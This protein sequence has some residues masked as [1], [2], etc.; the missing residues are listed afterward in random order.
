MVTITSLAKDERSAR[1]VLAATSEPDDSR[2]GRLVAAV[3][4]VDTVRVAMSDGALPTVLDPTEGELWRRQ[5]APRL[6]VPVV[7]TARKETD[8]LG[9][10]VLIPGDKDWPTGVSALRDREPLA[11]WTKGATSF[12]SMPLHDRVTFS[13]A[14]AA[15]SYGVHVTT[16]LVAELSNEEMFIVSGGAYG[17]DAAAHKAALAT[18]GSTIAVMAGGLDRP[19]PSGNSDLLS[20]VGDLGV[21]VSELPPGAAPTRW[22][23]LARNRIMAALSS[24]TIIPEAGYRS[25][26]LHVAKEAHELGRE[27]GAIPGAITSAASAGAH[28][29]IREGIAGIVTTTQDIRE[30]IEESG[31]NAARSFGA[32]SPGQRRAASSSPHR[33]L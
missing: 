30:M 31:G 23:F 16:E 28:R 15:T 9:L 6:L 14:R 20:R 33:S 10:H 27:V 24:A 25:G 21:L 13:G 8:K 22:R 17:I 7:E 18:G 12:L 11:L 1:I 3:G 5:L 26:S 29:L 2:T 32:T 4:A 19:Y